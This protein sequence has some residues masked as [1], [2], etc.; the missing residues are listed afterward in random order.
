MPNANWQK[1]KSVING[2]ATD[3]FN[4][5]QVVWYRQIQNIDPHGEGIEGTFEQ[6]NLNCLIGY[7]DFR[8]WPLDKVTEAGSI[9]MQHMYLIL[10]VEYLREN[11]YLN[12]NG[13]FAINVENDYF[14]HKGIFY[15]TD[16]DTLSAQAGDEPVLFYLVLKRKVYATG[17]RVHG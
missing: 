3:F 8:T 12:S 10:N 13:Y 4:Q 15:E 1:F 2:L 6:V 17:N 7:N 9:D 11:G 14:E 5:D 16:G